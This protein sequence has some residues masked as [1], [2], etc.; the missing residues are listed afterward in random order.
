VGGVALVGVAAVVAVVSMGKREDTARPATAAA[1]SARTAADSAR[2]AAADSARTAAPIAPSAPPAAAL[3]YV[4]IRGD[5]PDDAIIWLDGRRMPTRLF[6]ASPGGHGLEVETGE[7]EPWET[8]ITVRVGDTL[9]VN[10]ELVL[11]PP[12]DSLQ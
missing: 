4:R 6:Q 11:K 3:G 9:R 8:Q 5:L 12:S 2:T 7:F 1:D 10:V